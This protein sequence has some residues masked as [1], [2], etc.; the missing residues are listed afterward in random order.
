MF[1][2]EVSKAASYGIAA[3][4]L[5]IHNAKKLDFSPVLVRVFLKEVCAELLSYFR[6]A[7]SEQNF[8]FAGLAACAI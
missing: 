2:G 8:V 4:S 1:R 7:L 5:A 6:R 3:V